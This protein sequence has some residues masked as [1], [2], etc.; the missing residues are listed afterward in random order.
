M[1]RRIAI[2]ATAITVF[3][4]AGADASSFEGTIYATLTRIGTDGS[5]YVFTR[6]GNQLRIEN[7]SNKLEP[8]NIVDLDTNRLT[9]VYPHNTTFVRLDM[10]K[11]AAQANGM[12]GAPAGM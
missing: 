8:I 3:R 7:T 12:P 2:L 5:H 1:L 11:R 10:N 9:I 4:A 6:K